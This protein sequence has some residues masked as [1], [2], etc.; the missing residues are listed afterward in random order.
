MGKAVAE[1]EVDGV[2][3]RWGFI[4]GVAQSG[5]AAFFFFFSKSGGSTAREGESVRGIQE[6]GLAHRF[7]GELE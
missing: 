5:A 3:R 1:E 6:E 4:N 2:G 7:E